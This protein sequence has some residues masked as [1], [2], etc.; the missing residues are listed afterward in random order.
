M[1]DEPDGRQPRAHQTGRMEAFSD[2]VFAI[3]ITLL[4]LDISVPAG[5]QETF[6]ASSSLCGRRIWRTW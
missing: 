4:I 6:R 2:G 1:D 3:A 5:S